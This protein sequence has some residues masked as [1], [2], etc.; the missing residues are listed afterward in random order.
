[1]DYRPGVSAVHSLPVPN[2]RLMLLLYTV[3]L[4]LCPLLKL[5]DDDDDGINTPYRRFLPKS[6][7]LHFKWCGKGSVG[8]VKGLIT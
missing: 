5:N 8:R 2:D 6:I 3:T 4:S 7:I 1:M